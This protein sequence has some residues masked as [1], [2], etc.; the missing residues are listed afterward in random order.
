MP[1]I[2]EWLDGIGMS[3]YRQLFSDNRI[4]FDVL[5]DIGEDDLKDIGIP[6]GHRKR[7]MRAIRD[8]GPDGPGPAR[9]TGRRHRP[10][11]SRPPGQSTSPS[12]RSAA[13]RR[14]RAS[15]SWSPSSSPTSGAPPA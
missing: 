7:L 11:P 15:A 8:L 2:G 4:D 13:R 12:A 6:L 14:S 1:D 10:R 9:G 3:E 5:P